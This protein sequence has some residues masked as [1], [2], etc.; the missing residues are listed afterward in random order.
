M[1]GV[2]GQL[3][4]IGRQPAAKVVD[5]A[6]LRTGA[7]EAAIHAEGA[8]GGGADRYAET[9]G[10]G[11]FIVAGFQLPFGAGRQHAQGR[12]MGH[13]AGI[14]A[15]LVI[16]LAG[17]AVGHRLGALGMGDAHQVPGDQWPAQGR[18]HGVA[19][20]VEGA[21]AQGR[22]NVVA[23]VLLAQV[24]DEHLAGAAG[25]GLGADRRE[26]L[27]LAQVGAEGDHLGLVVLLQPAQGDRRVEP[28]GIGKDYLHG[29]SLP[30]SLNAHG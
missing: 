8:V 28:T 9:L 25:Q 26:V 3:V 1:Q 5:T 11:Q 17:G 21:G 29:C 12:V 20:L 4:G 16:A 14:E 10:V 15:H 2:R 7:P 24:F 30:G 13:H 19:P 22:E 23:Q 18:G 6:A 27:G